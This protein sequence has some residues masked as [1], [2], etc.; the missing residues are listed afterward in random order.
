MPNWTT[1][2]EA[3]VLIVSAVVAAISYWSLWHSHIDHRIIARFRMNGVK[4]LTVHARL[5]RDISRAL[6]ATILAT[7]AFIGL[8]FPPDLD[9]LAV[10]LKITIL[11]ISFLL[12]LAVFVEWR[13]RIRIDAAIDD[14]EQKA[15]R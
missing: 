15:R 6:C 12:G 2:L 3:V 13:W 4:R 7:S 11:L 14:A 5:I 9:P 1:L 8:Q 10:V